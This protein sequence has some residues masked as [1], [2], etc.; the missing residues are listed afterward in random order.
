MAVNQRS[1]NAEE[2]KE[3]QVGEHGVEILKEEQVKLQKSD[4]V[5]H[6]TVGQFNGSH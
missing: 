3:H 2:D 1:Q 6:Q 5:Y 4:E